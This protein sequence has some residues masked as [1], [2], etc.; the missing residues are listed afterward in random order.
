MTDNKSPIA[1]D[2]L[3]QGE[4][5]RPAEGRGPN[6]RGG[7]PRRGST[8]SVGGLG[9]RAQCGEGLASTAPGLL[10]WP[11]DRKGLHLDIC[12]TASSTSPGR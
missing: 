7:S 10:R 2:L 6:A 11:D 5:G 12:E 3:G 4:P 1:G 9:R 8:P